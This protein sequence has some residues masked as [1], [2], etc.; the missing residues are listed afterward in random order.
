MSNALNCPSC[1]GSNQLPEGKSSMFCSFC[2]NAIE[3][4]PSSKSEITSSIKSKPVISVQERVKI[5]FDKMREVEIKRMVYKDLPSNLRPGIFSSLEHTE[6]TNGYNIRPIFKKHI[7]G[8]NFLDIAGDWEFIPF[9]YR[10]NSGGGILSLTNKQLNSVKELLDWYTDDELLLIKTLDLS[11]NNIKKIDEL[12]KL[13]NLEYLI[14]SENKIEIIPSFDQLKQ[15]RHLDISNN[16]IREFNFNRKRSSGRVDC[17][18]IDLRNCNINSSPTNLK[19]SLKN[20]ISRG[21]SGYCE[22]LFDFRGNE[23][24]PVHLLTEAISLNKNNFPD[25]AIATFFTITLENEAG[26]KT[27]DEVDMSWF[28]SDINSIFHKDVPK[29]AIEISYSPPKNKSE[30]KEKPTATK[31]QSAINKSGKCFIATAAMGSY[32][33]PHVM[34]LRNFRDEWILTKNWGNSFV[35]WYYHYGEKAAKVI[36]KSFVLKKLSYLLI[37]KPLVYLSR[38]VKK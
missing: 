14:L 31:Q 23:F 36:D 17:C 12:N 21:K 16:P 1:G 6:A 19:E 33:H 27:T 38:I 2:G 18:Y 9:E 7:S 8:T 10:K 20:L 13:K 30:E 26:H 35:L 3:R 4:A 24:N 25:F 22:Y 37:V 11:V 29:K 28:F 5:Q 15:L 34:E 32:D